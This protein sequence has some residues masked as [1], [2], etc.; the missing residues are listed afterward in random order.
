MRATSGTRSDQGKIFAR[1]VK[2]AQQA[3]VAGIDGRLP[4]LLACPA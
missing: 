3:F 1:P 2:F 4:A